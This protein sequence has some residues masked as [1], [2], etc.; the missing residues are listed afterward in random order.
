MHIYIQ[1][2]GILEIIFQKYFDFSFSQ[3]HELS[4]DSIKQGYYKDTYLDPVQIL[5]FSGSPERSLWTGDMC[6]AKQQIMREIFT[7]RDLKKHVQ[8]QS[9]IQEMRFMS[10]VKG[11]Y[12]LSSKSPFYNRPST[13]THISS[14]SHS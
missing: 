8:N 11:E 13:P 12:C 5:V 4:R 10:C 6:R 3:T 2:H 14:S 7:D 1:E 9:A